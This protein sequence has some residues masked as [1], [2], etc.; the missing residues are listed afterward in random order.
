MIPWTPA[1][2]GWLLLSSFPGFGSRT[3]ERLYSIFGSDGENA[4]T[5]SREELREIGVRP[6]TIA[7][8]FEYREIVRPEPLAERLKKEGIR[9]I[10]S[11]DEEYPKLLKEIADPPRALFARGAPFPQHTPLVAVVGTRAMTAYGRTVARL[12]GHDLAQSGY[13]VVSGLALGIDGVVHEAV[14][15]KGGRAVAVLGCGIDDATIYPRTHA[16]LAEQILKHDGLLI[17]EFPPGTPGLQYHFPLRNRIIAGLAQTTIV[18]EAAEGSGSLITAHLALE[19]NREVLAVPGPITSFQSK[20]TNRLI[21]KGATPYLSIADLSSYKGPPDPAKTKPA[22]PPRDLTDSEIHIL[23][24]LS[25]PQRIDDVARRTNLS[26]PQLSA[27]L[28]ALELS[29]FIEYLPDTTISKT[30]LATTLIH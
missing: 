28:C 12:V 17:S 24:A 11:E 21:A 29:G 13:T 8:F 16:Q 22:I 2:L 15:E 1:R 25:E 6:K 30:P 7:S 19:S 23:K 10:L 26:I 18:V 20:G 14:V 9:F 3:L 5:V 4:C 27:E